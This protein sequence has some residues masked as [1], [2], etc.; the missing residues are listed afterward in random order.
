MNPTSIATLLSAEAVLQIIEVRNLN[1]V[2]H[3]VFTKL[4]GNTIV[5]CI[6]L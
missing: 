1:F 3:D 2:N 4:T 6:N 5:K